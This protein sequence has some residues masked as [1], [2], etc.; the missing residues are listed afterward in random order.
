MG[1]SEPPAEKASD[2]QVLP[3]K[4][5]FASTLDVAARGSRPLTS[6]ANFGLHFSAAMFVT[7]HCFFRH[8][9]QNTQ[10]VCKHEA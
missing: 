1:V 7:A 6:F 5:A 9:S 4:A 10:A 2:A 8:L 3:R